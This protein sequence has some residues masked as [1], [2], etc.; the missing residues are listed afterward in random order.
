MFRP[1]ALTHRADRLSGN[2]A[3]AV[4]ITWQA[5]G[6]LIFGGL[7][8]ALL[9]LWFASYSRIETVGGVIVP[10]TGVSQILPMRSGVITELRVRENQTVKAGEILAVISA[11]EAS[12]G[13]LSV[14]QQLQAAIAR[15]DASLA[16]VASAND[17]AASAQQSQIGAQRD[18]ISAEIIQLQSQIKLQRNLIGSAQNDL[19]RA[20]KIADRGFISGRDLQVR[21]DTLINR[22]QQL[23][24]LEQS[25]ASRQ[26]AFNETAK[27]A[28]LIKAQAQAQAANIANSRAEVSQQAANASG[29]RSYVLRAPVAGNVT[30]LS[31]RIGQPVNSQTQLMSIVPAG[32]VLRAELAISSAAIGFVKV[33]QDVRLAIDTFPYQRFGTI[34]GKVLTVPASAVSRAAPNGTAVNI[35]PVTIILSSDDILAFGR[36][37]KLVAG[38]TLT[39]RIVTE[40]QSLLEWLFEPLFAVRRR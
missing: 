5:M 23:S 36:R 38:M 4:P 26:S 25:L 22:Q 24:Q 27:N 32:S 21:E 39:A 16:A 7:V 19:D 10:D 9:F 17:I 31:A 12:S 37:E 34:K 15:Q 18:G 20:L 28:A 3:I 29:A 35:Y 1:E 2:V 40:K 33:G 30:A 13:Q 14:S 8:V 11:E 6:Y